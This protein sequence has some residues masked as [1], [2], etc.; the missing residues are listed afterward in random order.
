MYST[1]LPILKQKEKKN[2]NK[3]M[4]KYGAARIPKCSL[5]EYKLLKFPFENYLV[6]CTN[7]EHANSS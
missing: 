3:V 4:K 1:D 6:L 5:K 2:S 7:V